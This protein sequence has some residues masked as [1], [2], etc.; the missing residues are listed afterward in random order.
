[1]KI[2]SIEE[3]NKL[4]S[5]VG[6]KIGDWNRIEDIAVRLRN[7]GQ[8][9]NYQAPHGA[10]ELF[11]FASHVAAWLPKGKWKILQIDNSNYFDATQNILLQRLLFGGDVELGPDLQRTF[12]FEFSGEKESDDKTELLISNLIH[13]F[14]LFEG[15]AYFV[16]EGGIDGQCLGV[17]DGFVYFSSWTEGLSGA[18]MLLKNFERN[19]L[20]APNW[21]TKIVIEAQENVSRDNP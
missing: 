4:L 5:S 16:S 19:P 3:A 13:L 15:H 21:V 6:K 20:A 17:Q 9:S 7:N 11:N 8:W 1:M 14:L 18:E 2:L 12:L 10:K